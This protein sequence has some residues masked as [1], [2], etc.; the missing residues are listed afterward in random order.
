M[1]KFH[2][3]ESTK[4]VNAQYCIGNLVTIVNDDGNGKQ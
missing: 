4:K 1:K 3:E 2:K